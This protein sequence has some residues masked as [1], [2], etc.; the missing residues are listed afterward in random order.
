MTEKQIESQILDWLNLQPGIFA[1]KVNTTGIWDTKRKVF[2]T[3]KNKHIHRGTSDIIGTKYGKF[4]AIE[5]KTL[6]QYKELSGLNYSKGDKVNPRYDEQVYFLHRVCLM[7]GEGIFACN[8]DQVIAF[9][10]SMSI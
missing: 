8:L 7:G 4:F 1:F 9:V 6:K 2:R 3:I 5:V 10:E